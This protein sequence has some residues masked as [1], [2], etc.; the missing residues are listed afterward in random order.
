M[1]E[2]RNLRIVFMGTPLFASEVLEELLRQE[3]NVVGVVTAPDR[4]AGRGRELK[5]SAVKESVLKISELGGVQIPILQPEKLREGAFLSELE[6]LAADLF[7]VV[8][9]RM[10]PQVVW[11]MPSCGTFNL[12]ASLLPEYRGAAPINWAIINGETKSGVTTFFLNEEI[13]CGS[14]ILQR[15]CDI[16]PSDNVGTLHDKLLEIGKGLVVETVEA[17]A[18]Q[19]YVLKPQL[20]SDGEGSG[21]AMAQ[22]KPAPKLFKGDM[23]LDFTQSAQALHNKIRGLSPY[24][25][26]WGM[27]CGTGVVD[28]VDKEDVRAKFYTTHV[29]QYGAGE[30]DCVDSVSQNHWQSDGKSYL[31]LRTQGGWL[32]VDELQPENKKRM[33]TADFLRGWR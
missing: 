8:A 27:I 32:Y 14:V 11:A 2:A 25:T 21:G 10:L 18:A 28:G 23:E 3:F 7:I 5:C 30:C 24:P 26:A 33:A 20:F 15:E 22:L 16:L 31:R 17:I 13:D 19:S 4:P 6:A 1:K 12:H 9:F 29:E